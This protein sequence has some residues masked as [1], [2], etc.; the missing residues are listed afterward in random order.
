METDVRSN[1]GLL[2]LD[3]YCRGMRL[4][5]SCLIEADGGRK[6]LR[7][8]AGLGSGLE[9]ILPDGLWTNIPVV[10]DFAKCSPYT[11]R[12]REGRFFIDLEREGPVAE[13]RLSPQPPWYSRKTSS[14]KP[15]TRIG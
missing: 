6:I 8:R 5:D 2:K 10:E 15:M 11:L 12:H 14:G 7:T 1:P 3:L 9:A 13:I 4:D